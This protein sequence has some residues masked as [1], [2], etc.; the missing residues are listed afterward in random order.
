M[1][2]SPI[3]KNDIDHI[4]VRVRTSK[5]SSGERCYCLGCQKVW[6]GRVN[7]PLV[8]GVDNFLFFEPIFG[9]QLDAVLCYSE[10]IYVVS[11]TKF[12]QRLKCWFRV[13]RSSTT[14]S[15]DC[16]SKRQAKGTGSAVLQLRFKCGVSTP[17]EIWW[18]VWESE[19]MPTI[20]PLDSP[21][22]TSP[23]FV[24]NI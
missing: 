6:E 9:A 2:A 10:R 8:G 21:A 23:V 3:A 5:T 15:P 24:L 4:R 16:S 13:D 12:A 1:R 18:R 7:T 19:S 22:K 11:K 20:S 14:F 17:S